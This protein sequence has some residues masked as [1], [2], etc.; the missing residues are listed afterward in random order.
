LSS[1]TSLCKCQCGQK[2]RNGRKE[3]EKT[4]RLTQTHTIPIQPP[5]MP[6]IL[7]KPQSAYAAMMDEMSC[8]TQ[9]AACGGS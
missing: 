7:V 9:K 2:T 6:R 8:A 3:R 5:L 4:P 1:P